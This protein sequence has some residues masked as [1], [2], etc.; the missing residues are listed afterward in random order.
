VLDG[1]QYRNPCL[2]PA[3]SRLISSIPTPLPTPWRADLP[4]MFPLS[5]TTKYNC[6][7]LKFHS[8][9]MSSAEGTI[10]REDGRQAANNLPTT[11]TRLRPDPKSS[12]L[13]WT[14]NQRFA[15]PVLPAHAPRTV[16]DLRDSSHHVHLHRA[17]PTPNICFCDPG[18]AMRS[19]FELLLK[20]TPGPAQVK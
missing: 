6:G 16:T 13:V 20:N 15:R 3:S 8:D 7:L 17:F 9:C 14:P 10:L 18:F 4:P 5:R 11:T 2:R 19:S 12:S 1:A